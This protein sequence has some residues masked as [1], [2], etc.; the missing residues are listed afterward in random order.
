VRAH[1][2]DGELVIVVRDNGR[3]GASI[4]AGTGM[5]GIADRIDALDGTLEVESSAGAGTTLTIRMPLPAP[6]A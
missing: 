5:L 1:L 6:V 2:E 4:D 3:G